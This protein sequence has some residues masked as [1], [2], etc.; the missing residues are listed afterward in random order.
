VICAKASAADRHTMT[1]AFAPG[2]VEDVV[3]DHV[4]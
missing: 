4:L 3:H 1:I 2:E